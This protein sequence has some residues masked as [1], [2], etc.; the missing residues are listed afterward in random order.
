MGDAVNLLL[1]RYPSLLKEQFVF[2][3]LKKK[4]KSYRFEKIFFKEDEKA[5]DKFS[6]SKDRVSPCIFLYETPKGEQILG[7]RN[8]K[9]IT[10]RNLRSPTQELVRWGRE[11]PLTSHELELILAQKLFATI[12]RAASI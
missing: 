10:M 1:T 9:H 3:R 11:V 7:H 5:I 8:D 12:N 2:I 4:G 6:K